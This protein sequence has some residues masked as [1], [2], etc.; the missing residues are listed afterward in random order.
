MWR[1]QLLPIASWLAILFPPLL[2]IGGSLPDI[3]MSAIAVLFLTHSAIEKNWDW[4]HKRWI[5]CLL[6]LWLYIIARS[7]FAQFPSEALHRSLPFG[8]YFI[9][10]AAMAYWILPDPQTH[11]R[12]FLSFIVTVLF[13]ASDGLLQCLT[14]HDIIWREPILQPDGN[15]R[16]TGAFRKPILG[17]ML[18]WLAFPVCLYL[19]LS[20]S[21]MLFNKHAFLAGVASLLIVLATIALSGERM[22]LLLALFGGAI[23]IVC[24]HMFWRKLLIA[25]AAGILM[26][27][28]LTHINPTVHQRQGN[29]TL[30]TLT[31][32]W[33]S[34]YG[35][36][37][38]S[39]LQMVEINPIFGIGTN[40]FR[41]VCPTL[42][43][44]ASAAFLENVCK[45]HPHNIYMEWLIETGVIGFALFMG[46]LIAVGA[47]CWKIW[48]FERKN[49]VFIGFLIAFVLR[50]W[51]IAST[52]GV[53]SNWGAPP[54]W[55]VLGA[56]LVYTGRMKREN[57]ADTSIAV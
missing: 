45:I 52:T 12:F 42:Y 19:L 29:S 17:I 32:W 36:L 11:R 8:R 28:L 9:F 23:A 4:C 51:P 37:L 21:K 47:E 2:V 55:L 44:N 15:L 53:F 13:I 25:L 56:L 48:P 24:M 50:I 33:D 22:A 27:A 40:H 41:F 30:H 6:L 7:L 57:H 31:S 1:N 3:A 16:F 49:P 38:K 18:A 34:P 35:Q 20:K 43:P 5:Q 10:A 14:G 39:D 46:F 26:L 54:F